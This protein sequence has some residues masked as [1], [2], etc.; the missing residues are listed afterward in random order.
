MVLAAVLAVVPVNPSPVS[1]A[2][3][4]TADVDVGALK[5]MLL[6]EPAVTGDIECAESNEVCGTCAGTAE[7]GTVALWGGTADL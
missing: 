2:G 4:G 7:T 3:G 1:V 5:G 6:V